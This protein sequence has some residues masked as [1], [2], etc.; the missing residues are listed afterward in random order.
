MPETKLG[1]VSEEE[2]HL[3]ILETEVEF[4]TDTGEFRDFKT[5]TT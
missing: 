2:K 3:S 1:E 5:V 4:I